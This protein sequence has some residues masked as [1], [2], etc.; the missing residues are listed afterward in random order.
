MSKEYRGDLKDYSRSFSQIADSYQALCEG[1]T[2]TALGKIMDWG[3]GKVVGDGMPEHVNVVEHL[4]ALGKVY[5][6]DQMAKLDELMRRGGKNL[7]AILGESAGKLMLAAEG[8]GKGPDEV[9]MRLV[10]PKLTYEEADRSYNWQ[11]SLIDIRAGSIVTGA[12][13]PRSHFTI[14]VPGDKLMLRSTL[15]MTVRDRRFR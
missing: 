8:I 15:K 6:P 14:Y 1:L 7:A 10:S 4:K 13:D 12:A 2:D 3:V 5:A 11:G 9:G